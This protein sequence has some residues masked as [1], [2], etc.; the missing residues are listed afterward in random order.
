MNLRDTQHLRKTVAGVSMIGAPVLALAAAVLYPALS[1][2]EAKLLQSVA[3]NDTRFTAA[4]WLA[5]FSLMLALVAVLGLVHLLRERRPGLAHVGGGLALFGL[6]GV[7]VFQ[8]IDL[9]VSQMVRGGADQAEMAA[10]LERVTEQSALPG[11]GAMLVVV[12][13]I[14]LAA[15]AW[16]A[17]VM[18]ALPAVL[19]MAW[20]VVTAVGYATA[21]NA[22]IIA[23]WMAMVVGLGATGGAILAETDEEWEHAPEVR[24]MWAMPVH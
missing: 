15:S 17:H 11:F 23:G 5:T 3:E 18:P 12:G 6:I 7:A 16:R 20:A 10:L 2:D 9:V 1:T 8:G 22:L 13:F 24:G 19:I 14:V 21:E 4:V